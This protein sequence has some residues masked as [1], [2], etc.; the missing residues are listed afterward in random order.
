MKKFATPLVALF[1]SAP[2]WGQSN[3]QRVTPAPDINSSS[4]VNGVTVSG[5]LVLGSVSNDP[6]FQTVRSGDT[7][8]TWTA[9]FPLS[10]LKIKSL[11]PLF[12]P[13]FLY[14][15]RGDSIMI[16]TNQGVS[17]WSP[18]RRPQPNRPVV[19]LQFINPTQAFAVWNSP[20]GDT[21]YVAT[22]TDA[23][24]S[25]PVPLP[26][27][28]DSIFVLSIQFVDNSTG[29]VLARSTKT[30]DSNAA[31]IFRTTNGGGLWTK[32]GALPDTCATVPLLAAD[33]ID[34]GI[35]WAVQ[36]C[37]TTARIYQTLDGG[38]NWS[39]QDSRN[40]FQHRAIDAVDPLNVWV[41]GAQGVSGAILRTS[42][43]GTNWTQ[44]ALPS[45]PLPGVLLS[46][47]MLS[48]SRGFACGQNATL[49]SYAPI[50]LG[51][52]DEISNRPKTFDLFQ[53]F[54]NPFNAGTKISFSLLKRET[55]KL[56]IYDALGKPVAVLLEG[57]LAAGRHE[58]N[59]NGAGSNGKTLPTGLYLYELR[60][61]E[62]RQVR[63]MILLK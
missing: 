28:L 50:V 12:S 54:P 21:G 20:A 26:L 48:T 15:A 5:F 1:L 32:R 46:L 30:A 7:G 53:N 9:E 10:P 60:T 11:P 62:E 18:V 34:A 17:A 19:D 42:N 25:P 58:F 55:V 13:I 52:D 36:T 40:L 37:G 31:L 59:W 6:S 45:S 3:W 24:A 41:A 44:E 56:T 35:G 27:P 33:F 2:A 43:A 4:T 57:P 51:V 29:F 8:K 61:A 49:L 39:L 23:W 16:N 47:S 63:K 38:Q 22:T 14:G